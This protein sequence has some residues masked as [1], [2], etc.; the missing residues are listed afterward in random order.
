[1]TADLDRKL[2]A[3]VDRLGR[4][5]RA[6]RRRVATEHDLSLLGVDILEI[7]RDRRERRVGELAAEL[8]I[9]QP[10][11]SDALAPL[12]ARGL[13]HRRRDDADRRSTVVTLSDPGLLLADR[14]A[15][16]Q[17]PPPA[18]V[19]SSSAA[20]R[21]TALRVLLEE[22]ARLQAAG[23]ITVNRSCLSCRHYRA[24]RPRSTAH[25][26]LLDAPLTDHDLRV[27]CVEHE[28]APATA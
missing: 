11:V 18:S 21:G 28:G 8:D 15:A 10:T 22:I 19:E 3:A 9:T 13:L 2:L 12:E 27:D 16:E 23:V 17:T 20:E 1:M 4:A 14:I 24:P 6:A 5:L 25:C 26:L 7:L